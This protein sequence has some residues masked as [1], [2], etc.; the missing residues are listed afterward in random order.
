MSR[1]PF[2][3]DPC[4]KSRKGH[5]HHQDH[6]H[7]HI[8]LFPAKEQDKKIEGTGQI[9]GIE[10]KE[11]NT[12]PCTEGIKQ[13]PPGFQLIIEYGKKRHVL[14]ETID[15]DKGGVSKG[16]DAEKDHT[17]D[18]DTQGQKKAQ[19]IDQPDIKGFI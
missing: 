18:H 13:T 16:L 11:V 10:R 1:F 14:V 17:S 15:D 19:G 3:I 2:E 5:L 12:Q 8:E 7:S 6:T 4:S 9:V